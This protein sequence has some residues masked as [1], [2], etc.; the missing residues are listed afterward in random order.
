MGIRGA[1]A[2]RHAAKVHISGPSRRMRS[3]S[4]PALAPQLGEW[5]ASL[6]P[7][8][9]PRVGLKGCRR[10]ASPRPRQNV[11]R[12][13]GVFIHRLDGPR[14]LLAVATPGGRYRPA[15]HR[16]PSRAVLLGCPKGNTVL[17]CAY[18]VNPLVRSLH[19][20]RLRAL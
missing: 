15:P 14:V 3:A 20:F 19:S 7:V 12:D 16:A 8:P 4:G 11:P 9:T 2:S 5:V 13:R 18:R 6:M 17:A 1:L 10:G